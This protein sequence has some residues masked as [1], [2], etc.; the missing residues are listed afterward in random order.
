MTKNL[1]LNNMGKLK[2]QI[3]ITLDGFIAGPSGETDWLLFQFG[4]MSLAYAQTDA[5]RAR[6]F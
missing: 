2:L 3:Q 1:Y 6:L 5:A 4:K